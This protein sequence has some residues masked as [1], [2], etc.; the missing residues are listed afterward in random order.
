MQTGEMTP[1]IFRESETVEL[2]LDYTESIRK[3]V[4][5]FANTGGGTIYIGIA[6]NG[7]VIGVSS[8]DEMIQRVANMV[9]DS[10]RPDVTM[11]IHYDSLEEGDR[12]IV[13][14]TVQRGT[15]RPYYAA[16][17]GMRPSGV[18]VRQGTAAAPATEANIRQMIKETDG[19]NYED[20]RSLRQDLTFI[21]A[22]AVFS[23]SNLALEAPQMQT[24]GILSADGLFTNLGLLL[25]DQCPH[26][27]KAATFAGTNQDE[28]QDRREFTGSL[29]K[30]IDDAYAFLDMRNE[31]SATFE[32]IHRIDHRAYPA[33]ALREAL[34]NAVVHRDY[35]YSA[36][37]L[38]SVYADHMEI[39]SVG[40]LVSGFQ[41]NDVTAGL[42][43]CRNPK[44][45]NIFYRL[46]LIEA[47]GTG[48]KKILNAY[49]SMGVSQLFQV[50]EKVF[51]VTLPRV[52][53]K[54]DKAESPSVVPPAT[55][56]LIMQF[57]V[58]QETI[59]R[60]DV[61]RIAGISMASAAR[62]LKKMVR[63]GELIKT[64]EGKNTRYRRANV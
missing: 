48:L 16:E 59:T 56:D 45:A 44:L 8:V 7:E 61:E 5:A 47:Y 27:I 20:V 18:F 30:Q 25:S 24:L 58:S 23:R 19:D 51:K 4:I 55:E 13:R 62:V 60:A 3:D 50:T 35:A 42:S 26:I 40:G 38:I 31:T 34:L 9:R 12:K 32:G 57:L 33:A 14:L 37:T 46:S 29:L 49:P 11:F 63:Q 6:D 21:Y 36:S 28:F 39:V 10:I 52:N 22:E 1:F 53:N 17:K 64:G 2:K 15:G 54:H 41:L 43:I